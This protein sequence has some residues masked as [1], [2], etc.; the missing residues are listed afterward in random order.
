MQIPL[1]KKVIKNDIMY[2]NMFASAGVSIKVLRNKAKLIIEV[3][4]S[5]RTSVCSQNGVF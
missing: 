5:V 1:M 2:P 4:H 3:F